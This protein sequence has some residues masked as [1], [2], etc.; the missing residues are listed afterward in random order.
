MDGHANRRC[1]RVTAAAA[2]AAAAVTLLVAALIPA[3]AAAGPP[4]IIAVKTPTTLKGLEAA[5]RGQRLQMAHLEAQMQVIR[6]QYDAAV[7]D[8]LGAASPAAARSPYTVKAGGDA[9]KTGG[10]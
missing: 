1:A 10:G 4:A 5:A 3:R 6:T 8:Y 7:A 9:A 2:L